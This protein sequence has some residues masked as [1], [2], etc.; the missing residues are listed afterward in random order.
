MRYTEFKPLLIETDTSGITDLSAVKAMNQLDV[1]SNIA[2]Q[3]PEEK[4]SILDKLADKL[5]STNAR[6]AQFVSNLLSSGKAEEATI[7]DSP[8]EDELAQQPELQ[9]EP[10]AEVPAEAPPEELVEP[11]PAE[12]PVEEPEEEEP[13]IQEADELADPIV[14]T[15]E[16]AARLQ[17]TIEETRQNIIYYDSLKMSAEIKKRIIADLTK[18]LNEMVATLTKLK[19]VASELKITTE[20][21]RAA[22]EFIQNVNDLLVDL[23]NKVQ[24][25]V[26]ITPDEYDALSKRAQALHDNA[27]NFTTT[28]RQS[29]FSMVLDISKQNQQVDKQQIQDFLQ[30]CL[31]GNVINMIALVSADRGNVRDH[32]NKE[33][34]PMM[35]LFAKQKV[36]SWSPGK[37]SG[38]VGP[39]EMALCMMGSPSNKAKTKGDLEIDGE[40]YEIKA[41]ADSGGRLNSDKILKG[42]AAWPV[43][44]AGIEK[45]VKDGAPKDAKWTSRTKKGEEIQTSTANYS[46]NTFN[47]TKKGVKEASKYNFNKQGL[48]KLND[49]ILIYSTPELTYELFANTFSTLIT[50]LSEVESSYV[51]S[52]GN[53]FKGVKLETIVWETLFD[54]GTIDVD[55]IMKAYTRLAYES[56]N[57]ENDVESILFLNTRSLD[58]TIARNGRDMLAKLASGDIKITSGFNFNDSQQS[59]SPA[60][61]STV[62][63]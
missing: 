62:I 12:V 41:G 50:N 27:R 7:D 59:A 46:A 13:A 43:W 34:Q 57:R 48:T 23:G 44:K 37:T 40:D 45:I 33:W 32:V 29:L 16:R 38:A 22:E 52:K 31:D 28:F 18:N 21:L 8:S 47:K 42:P 35:D 56:Y 4:A 55:G 20:K 11:Q 10:A 14:G 6:I 15:E 30:A 26:A 54:D 9:S 60:Y 39:G 1:I 53:R 58:Y 17:A 5:E 25:Y 49:E 51:D 61:L 19:E 36:F 3:I 24:D 2:N 63:K